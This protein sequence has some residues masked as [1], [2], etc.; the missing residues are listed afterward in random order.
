MGFP[1]GSDGKE[2]VCSVGNLGSVP[3]TGRSPG[4]GDSNPLQYPCLENF[5][6]G[7][8]WKAPV[9]VGHDWVTSLSLSKQKWSVLTFKYF[10]ICTCILEIRNLNFHE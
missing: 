3:G 6:D 7:G 8:A 5:M 10:K 4:D 9:R 1:D 2:S